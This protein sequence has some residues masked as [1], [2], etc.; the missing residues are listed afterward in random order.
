M[1]TKYYTSKSLEKEITNQKRGTI[2][3][4]VDE[5][6]TPCEALFTG[7]E[8]IPMSRHIQQKAERKKENIAFFEKNPNQLRECI[9]KNK[10]RKRGSCFPMYKSDS[11]CR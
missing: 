5:L 9:A 7:T 3:W 8:W 11:V 6:G 2:G 10:R 1:N 4:T